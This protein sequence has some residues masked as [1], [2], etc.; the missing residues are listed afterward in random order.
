[1]TGASSLDEDA[2]GYLSS[3]HFLLVDVIICNTI[4]DADSICSTNLY[5]ESNTY[6]LVFVMNVLKMSNQHYS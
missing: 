3:I 1:M 2:N 5:D 6:T 4:S